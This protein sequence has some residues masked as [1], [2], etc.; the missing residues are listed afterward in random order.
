MNSEKEKNRLIKES[1]FVVLDFE[2]T[3]LSPKTSK[4]IEIGM[5]KVE[6]GKITDTY[7]SLI[8]PILPVPYQ[9]TL[10][11]GIS[12]DDVI[13]APIFEEIAYQILEFIGD[14]TL[15]AHNAP[16]DYSFLKSEFNFAGFDVDNLEIICTLKIAKRL[17][18]H[19]KS[20]S[21]SALRKH[22]GVMHKNVHRALGDAAVTAKIFLRMIDQ[23]EEEFGITSEQKLIRFQKL[24]AKSIGAKVMKKS[25]LEDFTRLPERPGVYLFLDKDKNVIYV[26]KSKSLKKR[27]GSYFLSTAESKAKKIVRK[28]KHIDFI[29]TNTELTALLTETTL[30]KK[31]LPERNSQQKRFPQTHFIRIV[32][33]SYYPKITS[34]G[35][36][37]PNSDDYF[38][39]YS[40]RETAAKMIEIASKAFKIRECT[41]K[42]FKKKKICYLADIERCLAPC[43]KEVK[44]EYEG[45]L[46]K[47]YDF[48]SGNNSEALQILLEKMKRLSEELKFEKAAEIRDSVQLLLNQILKTSV[49]SEPVNKAECLIKIEGG[50]NDDF[51]LFR[52]GKVFVK[53]DK[54]NPKEN[55]D[56]ALRGYYDGEIFLDDD[57]NERDLEYFKIILSWLNTHRSR[58]TI[59]YLK[60]YETPE[61]IFAKMR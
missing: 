12:Q 1:K 52:S 13:N 28:A 55:F 60:D 16:F 54:T 23:L 35:K 44:K 51:I 57:I 8:N 6:K 58:F 29:E 36:F 2:T 14:A 39:P 47:V 24:P 4:V 59:Y 30:I 56:D 61:E 19:L 49:L 21:L 25:L 17:L 34:A 15:V 40:N 18:P 31:Y 33:S 26:G 9:I 50:V 37:I 45:E 20:K 41:E 27:V 10:L 43:V 5:V 46:Q 22:Y 48:L 7:S 11:T 53:N 42:E 32:K 3:G 38:G